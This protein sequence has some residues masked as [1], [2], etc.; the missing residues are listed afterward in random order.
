MS[1]EAKI[2][3]FLGLTFLI[4]ALFIFIIGDLS[5]L[6]KPSGYLLLSSFDSALGIDKHTAVRMAGVKIGY[7]KEIELAYNRAL[8]KLSIFPG[9]KIPRDSKAYLASLGLL[10][11]RYIEI[12]PGQEKIPCQPGDEIASLPSVSFDQIGLMLISIG[13]EIKELSSTWQRLVGPQEKEN[14]AL[15]LKN[16]ASVSQ[17]MSQLLKST[18]PYLEKKLQSFSAEIAEFNSEVRKL[19]Q[20]LQNLATSLEEFLDLNRDN[21]QESL[22]NFREISERLKGNVAKLD[23]IINRLESGQGTLG[24]LLQNPELYEQTQRTVDRLANLAEKMAS[25]NLTPEI[26][27]DYLLSSQKLRGELSLSFWTKGHERPQ[28]FS[29][30]LVREPKTAG[31]LWNLQGGLKLGTVQARAGFFESELGVGLDFSPL[32]NHLFFSLESFAF[33]REMGPKWR[34]LSR[35]YLGRNFYFTIGVDD[36]GVANHRNLILGLGVRR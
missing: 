24:K 22:A 34:F 16:L 21:F 26:R 13:E 1:R 35:Y 7:V 4:L 29:L 14:F 10:G 25:A 5:R 3:F 32:A 11:E 31:F 17:E 18:Q 9:I 28:F 27:A 36:L 2:G 8:I 33:N 19:V 15:I 30:G 6:F 12:L 20:Q 23:Q